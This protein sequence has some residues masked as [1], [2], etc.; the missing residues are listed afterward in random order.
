MRRWGLFVGVSFS[1]LIASSNLVRADGDGPGY[2][3]PFSWTGVYMGGQ[4]GAAL[5]QDGISDPFANP[6][7]AFPAPRFG[8]HV[9]EPGPF[10]GGQI[11]Y[12]WQ[13][14]KTVYGVEVEASWADLDGTNTCFQAGVAFIGAN[15][16]VNK[17]AFGALTGRVGWALGPSGRTLVYAKGGAAWVHENV[18]IADNGVFAP[19]L[20][21]PMSS[22]TTTKWGWTVGTGVEYALTSHWSAK[23]EYDYLRFADQDVATPHDFFF[24]PAGFAPNGQRVS[25]SEDMHTV[26][27]GV[28]YRFGGGGTLD[29]SAWGGSLN[30]QP[31]ALRI[32]G[33]E[34]E[35]GGR[36]W[37]SWG[38]FQK[39]LAV[40]ATPSDALISRLTYDDMKTNSG[41]FFGRIDTPWNIFAKGFIGAG[42]T[43]DGHMN[44]EDWLNAGIIPIYSNTISD[45]DGHI[46]YGTIDVG[47][48]WLRGRDYK[49]GAFVG[50]NYFGQLM[51]ALG[52]TQLS[53][54]LGGCLAPGFGP[55]SATIS[56][57]DTW[58]SVR[59]GAAAELMLTNR[60]KLSGDVAYLPYV[61]FDGVDNHFQ[62][63]IH[64]NE[65]GDGIGV[66][67]EAMLSYQFT[68]NFS[69]GVGGRY[70]AM[71]TKSG[72]DTCVTSGG[73]CGNPPPAPFVASAGP[74]PS[75]YK[76][77]QFGVLAQA[78]YKFGVDRQVEPFK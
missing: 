10:A 20:G 63:A 50:Y 75:Q 6:L 15:C 19:I 28:N 54:G 34:V 11:G 29:E 68:D 44:D 36:Y 53:V 42:Q 3:R 16:H 41:E 55:N 48:D 57:D 73:T 72:E 69:L 56:E 51:R 61:R 13:T 2:A 39:D 32:A 46:R 71:R 60:L 17:D 43:R 27:L 4:L 12:N 64:F 59:V 65:S 76:V 52:C 30:D 66:Q 23:I 8:D 5:G 40:T 37:Y 35:L 78:T 26:K 74:F 1:A 14:G 31:R 38:R 49:I 47:Y 9:R 18:N 62:R 25:F 24:G 22:S 33:L 70:W 67:L 21:L 77:E 45:V 7:P 58:Q